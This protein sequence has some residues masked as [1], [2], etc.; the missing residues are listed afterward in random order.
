MAEYFKSPTTVILEAEQALRSFMACRVADGTKC[1]PNDSDF[2][3]AAEA[4]ASIWEYFDARSI[5]GYK[6]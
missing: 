5:P 4:L 3:M 2:D 1:A 6:K